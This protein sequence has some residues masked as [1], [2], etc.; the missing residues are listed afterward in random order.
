MEITYT[1]V[2]NSPIPYTLVTL[3]VDVCLLTHFLTPTD[4][5]S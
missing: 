2:D 3:T 1:I 5:V 4:P